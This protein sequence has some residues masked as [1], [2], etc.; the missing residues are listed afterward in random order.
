VREE[1]EQRDGDQPAA[2]AEERREHPGR[3]ADDDQAHES[4]RMEM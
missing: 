1:D 2:D 4:Y 3:E